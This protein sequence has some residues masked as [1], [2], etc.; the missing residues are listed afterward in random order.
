MSGVSAQIHG[1]FV[2]PGLGFFRCVHAK[3]L[4]SCLTLC[5]SLDGSPPGCSVC[6]IL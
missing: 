2:H 3:P 6:G 1:V 4:Q 5:D